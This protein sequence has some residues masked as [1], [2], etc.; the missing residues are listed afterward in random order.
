[1]VKLWLSASRT[2]T[3]FPFNVEETEEDVEEL[4]VVVV[5]REDALL[6]VVL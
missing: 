6:N 4:V 3:L 1:L 2:S 5:R